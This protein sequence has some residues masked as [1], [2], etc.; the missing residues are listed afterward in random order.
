MSQVY[1]FP[2]KH[3]NSD[4][5][6]HEVVVFLA[7]TN[8]E[9]NTEINLEEIRSDGATE[10]TPFTTSV[11]L[12]DVLPEGTEQ[13]L[14]DLMALHEEVSVDEAKLDRINFI[15]NS[16]RDYLASGYELDIR[17]ALGNLSFNAFITGKT[18]RLNYLMPASSWAVA[19]M[20]YCA[21]VEIA[22]N[23]AA[24]V[25]EIEAIHFDI[26]SNTGAVPKVTINGALAIAN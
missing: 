16:R 9:W 25:S 2:D 13:L 3:V 6:H 14:V 22:V 26:A 10:E 1:S 19:V 12:S 11:V 21:Q 4:R 8:V 23:A 17:L 5:L 18:N 7:Q 24:S 20:A 15:R